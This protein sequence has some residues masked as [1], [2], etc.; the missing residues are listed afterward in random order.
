MNG[1]VTRR[2]IDSQYKYTSA[3][4]IV[5]NS[6]VIVDVPGI[7]FTVAA[8][9]WYAVEIFVGYSAAIAA[10]M[11]LQITPSVGG[12]GGVWQDMG[13]NARVLSTPMNV[14]AGGVGVELP[15]FLVGYLNVG[16][17]GGTIKIQAAQWV[18]DVSNMTVSVGSWMSI[19]KLN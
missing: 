15:W 9:S 17:T 4:L 18:A 5:N 1:M 8:N 19:R 6:A 7:V 3:G 10:G 12:W 16:G 14:A 11:R 13:G 2:A